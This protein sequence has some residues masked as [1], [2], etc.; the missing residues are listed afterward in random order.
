M[1]SGRLKGSRFWGACDSSASLVLSSVWPRRVVEG[2][3][4]GRPSAMFAP[5]PCSQVNA[6]PPSYRAAKPG[7]ARGSR[8]QTVRWV[9]P[10]SLR[11]YVVGLAT[12]KS[13]SPPVVAVSAGR[14]GSHEPQLKGIRRYPLDPNSC[15]FNLT[16]GVITSKACKP[17]Y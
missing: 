3:S 10:R 12:V 13:G 17:V 7:T 2:G 5:P 4:R 14:L 8:L 11:N 9:R 16:A 1:R 6:P 15:S